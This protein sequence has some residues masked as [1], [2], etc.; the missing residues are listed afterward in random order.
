LRGVESLDELLV[1]RAMIHR[2]LPPLAGWPLQAVAGKLSKHV[3]G[4]TARPVR[5]LISGAAASG[6]RTF[7]AAVSAALGFPLLAID[8]ADLDADLWRRVY[9]RAQRGAFLNGYALAWHGETIAKRSWPG[10]VTPFPLQFVICESVRD[11]QRQPGLVEF[12]V[13]LPA[14][15]MNE[16]ARVWREC[17][18]PAWDRAEVE[19]VAKR[20]RVPVGDI[21]AVCVASPATPAEAGLRVREASRDRLGDLAQLLP[22]SFAWDDLVLP[23]HVMDTLRDLVYEAQNRL[24]FWEQPGAQRLF[25]LGRGL[26]AMFSGPSGTGK[27][28]AAQVIAASLG[29][30]LFRIDLSSVVSKYVGETSQNIDRVLRRAADMDAVLFFDEADAMFARRTTEIREALDKF[31]NTDAAHLLQAIESYPGVALLAT[32]QKTSVDQAFLRRIRYMIEFPKPEAAQRLQ[33]WSRVLGE[34]AGQDEAERLHD[35]LTALARDLE[36][37]GAQIKN[38]VVGAVFISRRLRGETLRDETLRDETLRDETLRG[39]TPRDGTKTGGELSVEHLLLSLERELAK[40]GRSLS[41]KERGRI[42]RS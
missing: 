39:E 5:V 33:I 26:I 42:R 34:L 10:S 9:M 6:R 1:G 8:A 15:A 3:S 35:D 25:P 2:P 20:Y 38:A 30:D 28:M 31:A 40:E 13:E 36:T 17:A 32:N 11:A 24:S 41:A 23:G 12:T 16:R 14:L 27:T 37:T 4:E 21:V 19:E 7:A 29:Y 22:C 18:P